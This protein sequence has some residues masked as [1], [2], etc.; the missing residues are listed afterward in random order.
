MKLLRQ[1]LNST[2]PALLLSLA[3]LPVAQSLAYP[4]TATFSRSLQSRWPWAHLRGNVARLVWNVP[5]EGQL[6]I[7]T[8]QTP[9]PTSNPPPSLLERYGGDLVLRF[10]IKS[11]AEASALAEAINI[12]FLDVWEFTSEWVDIRL[13]KDVVRLVI[14]F[15]SGS[16]ASSLIHAIAY[17]SPLCWASYRIRCNILIPH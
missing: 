10:E 1:I 17:R 5:S 4:A 11:A 13:S 7:T 16:S 15:V 12:L 6:K 8:P 3:V 2:P 14:R 9:I